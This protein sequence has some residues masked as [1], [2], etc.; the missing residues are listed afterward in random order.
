MIWDFLNAAINCKAQEGLKDNLT[1][2][3][4]LKTWEMTSEILSGSHV[5]AGK[6][7]LLPSHW[8][9]PATYCDQVHQ[10]WAHEYL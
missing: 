1:S 10:I 4:T 8:G 6:H 5:H 7:F 9:P 3:P 2:A